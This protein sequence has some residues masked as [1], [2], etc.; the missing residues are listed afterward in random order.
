MVGFDRSSAVELRDEVVATASGVRVPSALTARWFRQLSVMLRAGI[1]LLQ[2]LESMIA[3]EA[4]AKWRALQ[5]TL[6]RDLREGVGFSDCLSRHPRTFNDL[7]VRLIATGE[8]TGQ[9]DRTLEQVATL[10]EQ[11]IALRSQ[12]RH[13]LAYPV[14]VVVVAAAISCFMLAYVV[15]Q[16]ATLFQANGAQLPWLT[17]KLIDASHALRTNVTGVAMVC[18]AGAL[19]LRYVPRDGVVSRLP[20]VKSLWRNAATAR[21][22]STLAMALRAGVPFLQGL[23]LACANAQHPQFRKSQ[24]GWAMAIEDGNPLNV[25]FARGDLFAPWTLQMMAM[26][27]ESGQLDGMLERIAEFH[28]DAVAGTMAKLTVLLEPVV[29]IVIGGLVGTMLLAMFLPVFQMSEAIG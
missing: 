28:Q 5:Q 22:S 1:P 9:L 10:L 12:L 18:V 29:M 8:Q 27:Q 6:L 4:N 7:S 24:R 25:A 17:A 26:G 11:R 14:C 21:W 3:T 13:A 19:A 2:T 16:F 23:E 15:P 20:I